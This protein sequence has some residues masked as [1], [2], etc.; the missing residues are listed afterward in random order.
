M[1]GRPSPTSPLT[2]PAMRKTAKP[3]MISDVDTP[4]P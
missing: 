2:V 3:K 4:G 1:V